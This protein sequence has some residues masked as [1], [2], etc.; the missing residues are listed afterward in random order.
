MKCGTKVSAE[1]GEIISANIVEPIVRKKS[2]KVILIIAVLIVA[3]VGIGAFC[4]IK[5]FKHD[6][7][8]Y[9]DTQ[10]G[11]TI[12]EV[13]ELYPEA[14]LNDKGDLLT[15]WAEDYDDIEGFDTFENF[16]FDNNKLTE[17]SILCVIGDDSYT[18]EDLI[19][20]FKEKYD[21]IYGKSTDNT[22]KTKKSKIQVS[23]IS[24]DIIN[25]KYKDINT[26][27]D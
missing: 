26:A 21:K 15:N 14:N 18:S 7:G 3:L 9:R 22:W 10:W 11:M 23:V 27:Q 4:Y 20:H 2:K 19:N 5:Y 6:N 12:S 24:D 13:Q 17:T 1:D 8:F 16:I 25:I